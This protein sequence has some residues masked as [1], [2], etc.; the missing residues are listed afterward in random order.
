M[1]PVSISARIQAR[2]GA[3]L[4]APADPANP[5]S[6][7]RP[8]WYFLFL[9]QFLKYFHGETEV[10]G[11]IVI[12]GLVMGMLFLMPLIG[13][14]KLGHGFNVGLLAVLG[15]GVAALTAVAVVEDR[16]DDEYKKAVHIAEE[17]GMRAIELAQSPRGIPDVGATSLL[18]ND[19]KTQGPI[20]FTRHCA[21]CH[22]HEAPVGE[23]EGDRNSI[24]P[25]DPSAPDLYQFG[26][27]D[28]IAGF[29]DLDT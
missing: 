19:P 28:W 3:E 11:A 25:R 22:A 18:R 6:A 23:S 7:A 8:E 2:L 21:S 1:S 14:W 5:Y 27:R 15:I 26:S 4:G 9:F 12:P 16:G 13:R 10:F 20:L 24:S 17:D 29:L